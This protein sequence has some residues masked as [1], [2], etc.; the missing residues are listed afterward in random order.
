MAMLDYVRMIRERKEAR[1][2]EE[3]KKGLYELM[4]R[5]LEELMA[6]ELPYDDVIVNIRQRFAQKDGLLS[7]VEEFK[8]GDNVVGVRDHVNGII[9]GLK[10]KIVHI[11]YAPGHIPY[12][13]VEFEKSLGIE[14]GNCMGKAKGS[15]GFY[16]PAH[17]I[18]KIY[19]VKSQQEYES[20]LEKLVQ[21]R[22]VEE[23]VDEKDKD[24]ADGERVKVIKGGN[25]AR[26]PP[27]LMG[28]YGTFHDWHANDLAHVELNG[29]VG[30]TYHIHKD[31]FAKVKDGPLREIKVGDYVE[32]GSLQGTL[33]RIEGNH[34]YMRSPTGSFIA[35]LHQLRKVREKEEERLR[36]VL[37]EIRD[38]VEQPLR[39]LEQQWERF[40]EMYKIKLAESGWT[41]QQIEDY[42]RVKHGSS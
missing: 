22:L 20:H 41:N 26:E 9:T 42:F 34:A 15:H 12:Y 8:V 33:S 28:D 14:G 38:E 6:R 21:D 30:S 37:K 2:K 10:G 39:E 18:D 31:S 29:R 19:F 1:A 13:G 36:T 11:D 7:I 4:E 16:V 35:P 17:C 24:F 3:E 32:S 5:E 23:V 25:Y 40:T 27:T